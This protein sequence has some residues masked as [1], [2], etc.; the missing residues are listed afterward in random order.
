MVWNFIHFKKWASKKC[1][2]EAEVLNF[3]SKTC[4]DDIYYYKIHKIEVFLGPIL[5]LL[6]ISILISKH[7]FL[8]IELSLNLSTKCV[9]I[10]PIKAC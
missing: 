5:V 10:C 2:Y 6:E 3:I 9:L 8:K 4:L 1:E 7:R